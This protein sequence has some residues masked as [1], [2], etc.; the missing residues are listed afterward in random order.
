MIRT[1]GLSHINLNVGDIERSVRFYR[2]VFGLEVLHDYEGPMGPHPWGSQVVLSTPGA[3]DL[4]AIT[5][6]PGDPVGP[7]GINHFGFNLIDDADI[8]E[9]IA[10]AERAGGTLVRRGSAEIDG[11]VERFA[12][13]SD[14]DGY[15]IELN[16]QRVLLSR[17]KREAP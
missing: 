4:I 7:A 10:A 9:A 5:H 6:V 8:D 3:C 16:A 15:V 2:E 12:Y 11:I 17:K 14:P 1:R 13:V